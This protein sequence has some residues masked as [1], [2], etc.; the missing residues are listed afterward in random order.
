[1]DITGLLV[2]TA[3]AGVSVGLAR[4][5]RRPAWWPGQ[6]IARSMN[7]RHLGVTSWGLQQ[8]TFEPAFTIL[9]VGCGGGRTIQQLSALAP[10]GRV[11]GID[12]S[13]ASVAV[14]RKVNTASIAHGLVDIRCGSVS[15]LPFSPETFDVVTAVESHYYWPDLGRDLQE[16]RRVLK[17]GGRA[18]IIAEA[19][20][21]KRLG[22]AERIAMGLLGGRL[23]TLRE[24]RD[25][26]VTAG[27]SDVEVFEERRRGW[28]CAVG[29]KG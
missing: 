5:C 29:T 28:M 1:M 8:V 14:A 24:H 21:D 19:Y 17:P 15:N 27:Y 11:Y 2:L 18:V 12:Y 13:A 4:Q 20:R 9:D 16:I 26:L 25:A 23:L 22:A 6:L 3:I 7:A 10:R